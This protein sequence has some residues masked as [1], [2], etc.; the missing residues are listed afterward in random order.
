MQSSILYDFISF[1]ASLNVS[2]WASFFPSY[3]C[4]ASSFSS[5]PSSSLFFVIQKAVIAL[6]VPS[7][8]IIDLSYVPY[9]IYILCRRIF[10][11]DAFFM[12]TL[13]VFG[14]VA[15]TS[16]SSNTSHSPLTIRA[17][18]LWDLGTNCARAR[19]RRTSASRTY[20]GC[21][22]MSPAVELSKALSGAHRRWLSWQCLPT[23]A[24]N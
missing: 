2:V 3:S 13:S 5:S 23:F 22:A 18:V 11:S 12:Q 8:N 7:C 24:N 17:A 6:P 9:L 16:H 15:A 4:Y 21:C 1:E 14:F 20:R 10:C 19:P